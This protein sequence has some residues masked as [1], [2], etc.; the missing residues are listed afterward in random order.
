MIYISY[1][2]HKV[3]HEPITIVDNYSKA[4]WVYMLHDKSQVEKN[5]LDYFT[6]VHRQFNKWVKIV[7]IDNGTE[8]MRMK[9]YI[10]SI[11]VIYQKLCVG[12]PQQNWRVERKHRHTLNVGRAL[13][14]QANIHVDCWDECVLSVAYL[15]NKAI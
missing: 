14:F 4:V 9:E 15:I 3:L 10:R 5:I 11:G 8:V 2:G 12:T 1:I 6:L 13:M 7:R